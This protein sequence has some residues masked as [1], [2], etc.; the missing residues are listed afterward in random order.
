MPLRGSRGPTA[1]ALEVAY[2][3]FESAGVPI[4]SMCG[5]NVAV[6]AATMTDDYSRILFHDGGT[7]PRQA[8]TGAMRATASNQDGRTPPLTQPSSLAQEALIRH[9]YAKAGIDP[10]DTQYCEAHGAGGAGH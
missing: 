2:H 1:A 10:M 9:T 8:A 6:F 5:S 7:I 3:A 4:E